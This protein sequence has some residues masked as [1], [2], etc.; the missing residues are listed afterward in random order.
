MLLS[1]VLVA[2]VFGNT[3]NS[4]FN[5]IK[6]TC[7]DPNNTIYC[8]RHAVGTEVI[9]FSIA[10]G[11]LFISFVF[12]C[13]VSAFFNSGLEQQEEPDIDLDDHYHWW[14]FIFNFNKK[15][16]ETG[17]DQE[18]Q[19]KEEPL[20]YDDV[21]EKTD[22]PV[23]MLQ[24][25]HRQQLQQKKQYTNNNNYSSQNP[26]VTKPNLNFNTTPSPRGNTPPRAPPKNHDIT[27]P[28]RHRPKR[29]SNNKTPDKYQQS[30]VHKQPKRYSPY[31][32]PTAEFPYYPTSA[33][34][35]SPYPFQLSN[36]SHDS[37]MMM[38]HSPNGTM[39]MGYLQEYKVPILKAPPQHHPLNKKKI[40][41]KRIQSYLQK[42]G[43]ST[44]S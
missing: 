29:T 19:T 14:R 3:Y 25:Y 37:V 38:R 42:S 5:S 27:D 32:S 11:L 33:A 7:K 13:C 23:P 1:V 30:P 40:T 39:D 6:Q 35:P 28:R 4:Y 21:L 15:K 41:D 12:W 24:Q 2:Y 17:E 22:S 44:S 9:V 31:K 8:A 43:S 36:N 26:K 16:E 34:S 20:W 10:I 18:Q